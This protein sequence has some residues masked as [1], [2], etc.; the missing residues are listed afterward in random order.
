VEGVGFVD[1]ILVLQAIR[2]LID[3]VAALVDLIKNIKQK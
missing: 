2:L 3:A 1:F